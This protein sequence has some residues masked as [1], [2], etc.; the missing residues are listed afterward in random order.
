MPTYICSK[1]GKEVGK[2]NYLRKLKKLFCNDCLDWAWI[3][4]EKIKE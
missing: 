3:E 4:E 2:V 1:C